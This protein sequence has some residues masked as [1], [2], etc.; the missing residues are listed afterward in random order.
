M[1]VSTSDE[2]KMGTQNYAPMLQSQ[3]GA[4]DVDLVPD[5]TRRSRLGVKVFSHLDS[6]RS[7]K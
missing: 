2:I 5:A 7:R 3:G 1:T 4:Y 6:E